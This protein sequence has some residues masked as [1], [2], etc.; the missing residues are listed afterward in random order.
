MELVT[1][2]FVIKKLA[3]FLLKTQKNCPDLYRVASLLHDPLEH[4]DDLV[5]PLEEV[6]GA[7]VIEGAV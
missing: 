2:I 4:D 1:L 6:L 3:K 7:H 5:S